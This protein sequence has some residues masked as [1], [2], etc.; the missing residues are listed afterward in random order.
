MI[1]NLSIWVWYS[2]C[3]LGEIGTS[4]P[5]TFLATGATGRVGGVKEQQDLKIIEDLLADVCFQG[6]EVG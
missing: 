6:T 1:L 2:A 3:L 4:T 5:F